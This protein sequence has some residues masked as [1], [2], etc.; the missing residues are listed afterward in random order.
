[1]KDDIQA[2]LITVYRDGHNETYMLARK[3]IPRAW[4]VN[5]WAAC[6]EIVRIVAELRFSGQDGVLSL[7]DRC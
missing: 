6:Q 1:M 2:V 3:C 7:R 5:F 4:A